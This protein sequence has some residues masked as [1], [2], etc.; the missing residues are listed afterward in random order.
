LGQS[1]NPPPPP[2]PP[3]L[4]HNYTRIGAPQL[5][6]TLVFNLWQSIPPVLALLRWDRYTW[7]PSILRSAHLIHSALNT[8]NSV[9]LSI[10]WEPLNFHRHS[11]V[12][13]V[14]PILDS[15]LLTLPP[16][17]WHSSSGR[18]LLNPYLCSSAWIGWFS[19]WIGDY[20]FHSAL[21]TPPPLSFRCS[22]TTLDA[23][24]SPSVLHS[25]ALA[26]F[27]FILP[28]CNS[29]SARLLPTQ[30][31]QSSTLLFPGSWSPFSSEYIILPFK[32]QFRSA[33]S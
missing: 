16:T 5:R 11:L 12:W 8:P 23:S 26:L 9:L 4:G 27:I 13:I 10:T 20:W 18:A 31:F 28:S 3:T 32:P 22:S 14:S 1:N 25:I 7:I 30:H 15:T 19:G 6:P 2:P 33:A 24:Q 29:F 17:F 21:Q